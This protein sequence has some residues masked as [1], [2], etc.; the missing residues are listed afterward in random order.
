[1]LLI[2]QEGYCYVNNSYSVD[3]LNMATRIITKLLKKLLDNNYVKIAF[4]YE[5][6]SKE[7]VF[8]NIF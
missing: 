4:K 5:A 3:K 2:Y 8:R 1:M 7:V 6:Y